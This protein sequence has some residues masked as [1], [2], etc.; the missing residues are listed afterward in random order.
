MAQYSEWKGIS[1]DEKNQRVGKRAQRAVFGR[2]PQAGD[3]SISDVEMMNRKAP[4]T[5]FD[6]IDAGAKGQK[7]IA[8]RKAG[9]KPASSSRSFNQEL[10][11]PAGQRTGVK[12]MRMSGQQAQMLGDQER[13]MEGVAQTRPASTLGG[14]FA[15][16]RARSEYNQ[17]QRG[18]DNAAPTRKAPIDP[19]MASTKGGG[20]AVGPEGLPAPRPRSSAKQGP[21]ADAQRA[22]ASAKQGPKFGP[23]D[24]NNVEKVPGYEGIYKNT[25]SD[26]AMQKEYGKAI[27]SDSARGA[28]MGGLDQAIRKEGQTLGLPSNQM[29]IDARRA[30]MGIA[31]AQRY[32]GMDQNQ[33]GRMPDSVAD[34]MGVTRQP[35]RGEAPGAAANREA[36]AA[37]GGIKHERAM[38]LEGL[39]GDFGLEEARIDASGKAKPGELFNKSK[40]NWID[41]E[42]APKID[43][44][45]DHRTALYEML[46]SP[47]I[48]QGGH[49]EASLRSAV[50]EA[51]AGLMTEQDA[52]DWVQSPDNPKRLDAGWFGNATSEQIDAVIAEEMNNSRQKSYS[53]LFQKLGYSKADADSLASQQGG[54]GGQQEQAMP[55]LT[56]KEVD[57]MAKDLGYQNFDNLSES[58]QRRVIEAIQDQ[59][60]A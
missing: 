56:R 24:A 52:A 54:R 16:Y 58:Q 15:D 44:D 3:R 41:Q 36:A 55:E 48:Q 7:G 4:N 38:E 11:S 5:R 31:Q 10:Q 53:T 17:K 25:L 9:S 43:G 33:R 35:L 22:G 27:F 59:R 1:E 26:P 8:Q 37:A 34:T 6:G 18:I 19:R 51:A 49:S 13:G 21:K 12:G 47:E 32:Y 30:E 40:M 14:V 57:A 23:V 39:K 45:P 20:P 29:Q 28:T 46:S 60:S 42:F 2:E 50:K